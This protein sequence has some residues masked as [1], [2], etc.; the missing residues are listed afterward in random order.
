MSQYDR[1]ISAIAN[2]SSSCT[3]DN[4]NF[5]TWYS[6]QEQNGLRLSNLEDTASRP[7]LQKCTTLSGID[8]AKLQALRYLI[9]QQTTVTI[10]PIKISVT[11]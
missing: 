6:S 4:V 8:T 5:M 7:L 2:Y 9:S 11:Q 3:S 1:L 10:R